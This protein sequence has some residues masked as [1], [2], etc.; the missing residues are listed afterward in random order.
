MY[1]VFCK[2]SIYTTSKLL[3]EVE[4]QGL[5][6]DKVSKGRFWPQVNSKYWALCVF[7]GH[8]AILPTNQSLFP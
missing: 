8:G 1:D 7:V 2:S 3:E 4:K 6:L 5:T